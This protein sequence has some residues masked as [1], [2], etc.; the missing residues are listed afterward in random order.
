M[1]KHFIFAAFAFL[2]VAGS[3][4]AQNRSQEGSQEADEAAFVTLSANCLCETITSVFQMKKEIDAAPEQDRDKI[5]A[6]AAKALKE[7]AC[8]KEVE[9]ESQLI[10][11]ER[12]SALEK[13]L[14]AAMWAKCGDA[15]IEIG[16]PK[17][18]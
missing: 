17:E 6:K 9:A 8:M 7:P 4:S 13:E 5:R 11:K 18:E 1:K 3:L 15:M 16:I 14:K 12:K 10:H 2:F